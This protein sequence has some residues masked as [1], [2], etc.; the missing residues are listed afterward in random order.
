M[1]ILLLL[2]AAVGVLAFQLVGR[3]ETVESVRAEKE[4]PGRDREQDK[5]EEV[6][7]EGFN[8]K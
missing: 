4:G 8:E 3:G 2:G 7:I 1:F 5:Y 6:N